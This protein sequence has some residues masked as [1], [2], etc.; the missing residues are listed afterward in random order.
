[1]LCIAFKVDKEVG[2]GETL[3]CVWLESK[4]DWRHEDNCVGCSELFFV[5]IPIY[6]NSAEYK[7]K[8]FSLRDDSRANHH[9]T[10]GELLCSKSWLT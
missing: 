9:R 4:G 10:I 5:Q 2:L 1:M 8:A 7:P 3:G 6:L